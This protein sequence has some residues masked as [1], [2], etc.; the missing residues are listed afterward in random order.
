[1]AFYLQD[2]P[3]GVWA[4][5]VTVRST[6]AATTYEPGVYV[7]RVSPTPLLMVVA[8][9]DTVTLTDTALAAYERAREPKRLVLVPGGH[10]DPYLA[11]FDAECGAARTWLAD[12][13]APRKD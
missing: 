6:L 13:L 1:M 11:G 3:D 7:D 12:H 5:E 4:N 8:T 10:F 2:V 9:H